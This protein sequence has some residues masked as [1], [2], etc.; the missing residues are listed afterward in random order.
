MTGV[1]GTGGF[2]VSLVHGAARVVLQQ[3]VDR[4]GMCCAEYTEAGAALHADEAP[5][6]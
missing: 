4:M 3:E 2:A 5:A 1:I 6:R